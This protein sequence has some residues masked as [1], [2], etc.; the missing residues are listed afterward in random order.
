M[1][2]ST[3]SQSPAS[4]R[5]IGLKTKLLGSAGL[6]LA[7]MVLVGALGISS[8][9][10]VDAKSES[11]QT[12]AVEP[13][14][15]LGVARAQ[16]NANHGLLTSHILAP[17]ASEFTQIEKS[18]AAGVGVVDE[19]L[20]RIE[21]S[22]QTTEQKNAFDAIK[23]SLAEY[24]AARERVF[25]TS[26]QTDGKTIDDAAPIMAR[27]YAGVREQAGPAAARVASSFD[28]LYDETVAV[29]AAARKEIHSTAASSRTRAI[30]VI[31]VALILGLGIALWIANG[32]QRSVRL[33]LERLA[34]LRDHCTSD[35][36][37]ALQAVAGGDLTV[38]V[39]PVT[40]ELT[41]TSNDEIGDVAEAVG[42]IRDSTVGSVT[43]YN[44]TREAL[45]RLI[46]DVAAS[47]STVASSSEEMAATSDEAGRAVGEIAG[48]VGEVAQGAERQVRAI[49]S[50]RTLTDEMTVA[51][52]QSAATARETADVAGRASRLAE[53]GAKA[54][55]EATAAMESVRSSSSEASAAIRDLGA[56]SEQ[57]TTIVD[58]ITG[59]AEQTNLLALNA[60]IEA[61]RAGEQ[62]RGFAVVAEE[63]RKLAE[64]SQSAAASIA[65]LIGQ[66]QHET[67]RTVGVVEAGAQQTSDGAATVEAARE[68]FVE[69]HTAVEDMSVRVQQIAA[70]IH[71]IAESS[72]RVQQDISDVAAVA[73]QSSAAAEQVSAS[74]QQTSASTQEIAATAQELA[75]ISETLARYVA[76]FKLDTHEAVA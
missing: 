37:K 63:V 12:N 9:S 54:V 27:A 36:R 45:A 61:A 68:S 76:Q 15:E 48:G 5:R 21:P 24:R 50:A 39:T 20:T 72:Q 13:L 3:L 43:A 67:Q 41:R 49:D 74:T 57:I 51:T 40:P 16:F 33:I 44:E 32:I 31:A 19:Q 75:T 56:K 35:L 52:Q 73:E 66:I 18:I 8:L 17:D 2:R 30:A 38:T 11:M 4:S 64:E 42:A 71:Q 47:A 14:A 59:I 1:P 23:R 55:T 60:A 34:S 70:A 28:T 22:L 46:G 26:R 53:D 69:I 25:E 58:T 29:A 62:G 10:S 6:L 65:D 7:L